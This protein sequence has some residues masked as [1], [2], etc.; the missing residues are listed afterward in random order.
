VSLK[1]TIRL[2]EERIAEM[3]AEKDKLQ[4]IFAEKDIFQS[5]NLPK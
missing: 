2:Q 5:S 3:A 4:T 1:T